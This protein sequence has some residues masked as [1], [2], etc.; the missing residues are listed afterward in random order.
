MNLPKIVILFSGEGGNMENIITTLHGKKVRVAAA[1]TNNPHAKGVKRAERLGILVEIID[2]NDFDS[3]ERFDAALVTCIERYDPVLTVMAGFMRI[4]TPVFTTKV[5]AINI[6]PSYLPFHKGARALEKSFECQ[7]G[8][9]VSIH[10]VSSEL[11][12]GAVIV[13]EPLRGMEG[14]SLDTYRERV[15]K[16][17]YRLYPKA[18]CEQI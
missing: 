11:D 9:G 14:E 7:T 18:I 3:R 12:S 2:H 17:E 10:A 8:M 15:R 6:H 5:K 16:L 13:Q 4:V 1:I